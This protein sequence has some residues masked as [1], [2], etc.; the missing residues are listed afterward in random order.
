MEHK[1]RKRFGQN[2]LYDSH[3]IQKIVQAINPKPNE[4]LVEIGPGL[5][6]LTR[7]LI[8]H[9]N[10]LDIIEIDRDLLAELNKFAKQHSGLTIHHADALKFNFDS[11][12][13]TEGCLRVVGN[14]PYNISTPLL[15]HLIKQIHLIKDMHFMLQKEVVERLAAR[16]GSSDYGRLSVMV[17]YHC[18]VSYLF[19]VK[20]GAFY[21]APKVDSAIVRLI[22]HSTPPY[23]AKD[24]NLFSQ[25]ALQAFN[26]RRKT[27]Q[28]SL[29]SYLTAAQIQACAIDP[30]TRPERLSVAEF[31][32]LSNYAANS[33]EDV[34]STKKD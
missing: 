34:T 3:I 23:T 18:E 24:F 32:T 29:K 20:P 28:N 5:G 13:K 22:P 17:Q 19:T 8:Q 6:A 25:I 21:P 30:N 10:Q 12:V 33:I 26:Q 2:F 14:L 7:Y 15:F 31:V 4:H 11:L 1:P 27:L 16:P 9:C